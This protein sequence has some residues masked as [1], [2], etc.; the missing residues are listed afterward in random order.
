MRF[1]LTRPKA[2]SEALADAL[3]A[4]GHET[5]AAPLLA[6]RFLD[7][8][9]IPLRN[10]Q[11]LLVT[12][13]NGAKAL[14]R[15]ADT[16]S[17]KNLPVFAVGPASGAAMT[18]HGFTDVHA[19]GGDVDSLAR[20]VEG[21]L[22]PGGGPL[23]HAAGSVVAGDLRAMLGARGFDVERCVLYHAEKTECLPKSAA[24]AVRAGLIDGVLLYS[25]RTAGHFAALVRA[26]GLE[27]KL[28]G[29]TVYCLSQAVC[30]ALKGLS[31]HDVKIAPTPDQASLL[32][33]ISG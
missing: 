19:A 22:A 18:A 28:G 9:K 32:A 25:P 15:R 21:E 3:E 4:L 27:D 2:D 12:S 8:A 20:L 5:L 24:D 33:L 30:D 29:I 6:I 26:A 10:W 1:L 23:L 14:G 7:E 31:V 13:A 17:L 11:A 16:G